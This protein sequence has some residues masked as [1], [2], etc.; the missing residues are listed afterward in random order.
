[1]AEP[2]AR[3]GKSTRGAAVQQPNG[4]IRALRHQTLLPTLDTR[5][6]RLVP[7]AREQRADVETAARYVVDQ[8]FTGR[9][10][11]GDLKPRRHWHPA[12][13]SGG[14]GPPTL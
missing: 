1:M 5:S 11:R 7:A 3:V 13:R 6:G 2:I 8:N 4:A 14:G 9:D 12:G 10:T